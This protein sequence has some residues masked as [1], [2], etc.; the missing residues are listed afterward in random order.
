PKRRVLNGAPAGQ[1]LF[2]RPERLST[3]RRTPGG[4][5]SRLPH[6][7]NML[8]RFGP[9][10]SAPTEDASAVRLGVS[11]IARI[12]N[13]AETAIGVDKQ[14]LSLLIMSGFGAGRTARCSFRAVGPDAFELGN[15]EAHL[16][17]TL[18]K[19]AHRFAVALD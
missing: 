6:N 13:A 8:L 18:K 4:L 10:V 16:R 15:V 3:V 12:N 2:S 5:N 1:P 9:A 14:M 17:V 11:R 7:A 19:A